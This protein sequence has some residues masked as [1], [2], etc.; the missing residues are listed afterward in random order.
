MTENFDFSQFDGKTKHQIWEIL[1]NIDANVAYEVSLVLV[2]LGLIDEP[3][4]IETM[5]GRMITREI[6][7]EI[8]EDLINRASDMDK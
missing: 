4:T 7:R 8:A 3:A 5:M 6:D 1:E 2:E